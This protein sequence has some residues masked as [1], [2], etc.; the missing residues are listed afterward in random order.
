MIVSHNHYDHLDDKTVRQLKNKSN[1]HV[2][3]PLGLKSFFTER[4]YTKVTELEAVGS[5]NQDAQYFIS[6]RL[7]LMQL[8]EIN[9]QMEIVAFELLVR[10]CASR[11][12]YQS[13]STPLK[14][15]FGV[16]MMKEPV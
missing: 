1:I 9:H 13:S 16:Y 15:G 6:V 2:V 12:T 3:V 14:P 4:G 11:R 8:T 5:R 10:P 7:S